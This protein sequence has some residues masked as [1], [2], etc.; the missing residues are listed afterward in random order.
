MGTAEEDERVRQQ[1]GSAAARARPD[2][3]AEALRA[4]LKRRKVQARARDEARQ[5]S[6]PA[7]A[8]ERDL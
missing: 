4:N 2:R 3:R 7:D 8:L 1:P 5:D 6:P